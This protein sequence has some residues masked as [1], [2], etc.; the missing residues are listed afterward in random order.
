M[1]LSK[2]AKNI[3]Q[4]TKYKNFDLAYTDVPFDES[5]K[6]NKQEKNL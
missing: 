5:I 4:T 2:I 1:M 3:T 6:K